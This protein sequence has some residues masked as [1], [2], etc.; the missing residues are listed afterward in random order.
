MMLAVTPALAALILS[1]MDARLVSPAPMVMF[2]GVAP[3]LAVKPLIGSP[4]QVPSVIVSVP[5]ESVLLLDASVALLT[6][7]PL[8]SAVTLTA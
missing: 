5:L 7:C 3:L 1:R 8:A 6:V 2:T 4:V